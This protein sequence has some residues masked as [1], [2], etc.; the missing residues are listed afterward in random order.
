M[1]AIQKTSGIISLIGMTGVGKT[2]VGQA[3]ADKLNYD[4]LD[5]DFI[6]TEK[7]K[8]NP[9]EIFSL[10]GEETFR[11][12]ESAELENIFENYHK[13]L[14]LSC[15]GGVILKEKNREILKKN[16]FVV[17]LLRPVCEIIKND[18][19]LKRPPINGD[20]NNY[21]ELLKKREPLYSQT[22]DLKLEYTDV[23]EAVGIIIS[24]ISPSLPLSQR[25]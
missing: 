20:I 17:W 3:L 1:S 19:I 12:I 6:I 22:G 11:E 23:A 24:N 16:S 14:I 18:E 21:I 2:K 5:L 8:K 7:T 10:Y 15:G 9:S 13:N 4:F 25:Q